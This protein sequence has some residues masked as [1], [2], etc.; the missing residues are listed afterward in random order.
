[1]FCRSFAQAFDQLNE[2]TASDVLSPTLT[3]FL[4]SKLTQLQQLQNP[5]SHSTLGKGKGKE[6]ESR[7]TSDGQESVVEIAGRF[8]VDTV[9]ATKLLRVIGK[10]DKLEDED[11]DTLTAY[12]FEERTCIIAIVGML[13]R[14]CELLQS[15]WSGSQAGEEADKNNTRVPLIRCS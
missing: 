2:S 6:P 7:L 4:R 15:S 10:N 14:C 11:W 3:S 5:F 12:V 9:E 8:D 1:M 13:L